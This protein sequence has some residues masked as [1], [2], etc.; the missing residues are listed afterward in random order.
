MPPDNH[1]RFQ[2]PPALTSV[3]V[4]YAA[5]I[6][7]VAS[8]LRLPKTLLN[9]I[10]FLELPV[11]LWGRKRMMQPVLITAMAL[12]GYQLTLNQLTLDAG[13]EKMMAQRS[14]TQ[15]VFYA[16]VLH[17][18]PQADR[19]RMDVM[20]DRISTQQV[21]PCSP[22][23]L[24]VQ[25]DSPGCPLLPG[26]RIAFAGKLRRPRLFGTPG[27]FNG[28]RHLAAQ[29]IFAT[30]FL[31]SERAIVRFAPTAPFSWPTQLSRWRTRLARQLA[32]AI[33]NANMPYLLS[34]TLGESSRLSTDQRDRLARGGLSHLFAI[35]GLHLGWI[36]SLC[37]LVISTLYRRSTRLLLWQPVQCATPFLILPLILFYVF[38]SG[39][40]LPTQRAAWMVVTGAIVA[41]TSYH[42]RPTSA[43]ILAAG[44]ILLANPLALLS[45][46][47]QLSFTAVAALM[48][49]LPAW[50]HLPRSWWRP[51]VLLMLG[52]TTALLATLP[53]SLWHFHTVAPAALI[54]NLLAIPLIGLVILPAA[55]LATLL[56]ALWPGP[57]SGLLKPLA[58]LLG[59]TLDLCESA[60]PS[61]LQGRLLYLTPYQHLLTGLA[62]LVLLLLL[63]RQI[64]C[65]WILGI[66]LGGLM[67]LSQIPQGTCDLGLSL[68]ALSVGQGEALLV[69]TPKGQQILVDG[70]GFPHSDFDVG[71]RLLAPAL[72]QLGVT[73]LDA[74]LLTHDHPDHREGLKHLLHHV[75]VDHFLTA[76][77]PDSM[78]AEL[79]TIVRKKQIP[80]HQL[81]EGW[82]MWD[83]TLHLFVPR[84]QRASM[85]DR[86]VALYAGLGDDGL[87]L[88]GD[89]EEA[90]M[91]QLLDAPPPG[92]VTLL[93]LPHHGSRHTLPERWLKQWSL[94]LAVVSCGFQNHFG[95]PHIEVRQRLEQ[96]EIPL[97]RTDLDGTVQAVSHGEGWRVRHLATAQNL[98]KSV[99]PSY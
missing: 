33:E 24:R 95:F 61:L 7:I 59:W 47:F 66:V 67:L 94:Q 18:T 41:L 85:N 64:R 56:F 44:L 17:I 46:S 71:R 12:L 13:L 87:L 3:L 72:A 79:A 84:Q 88:T 28:P 23:H 2:R 99:Q 9:A 22:F 49:V 69:T 8:G 63:A 11:L 35:S 62:C 60:T 55:L 80:L 20:V 25:I 76:L 31:N 32:S 6:L 42:A 40:A 19:W 65:G 70:G 97:L 57:A 73:R 75:P 82:Q 4:A 78:D 91:R 53:V 36:A 68:T 10:L 74:V 15:G 98:D 52:S 48:L 16:E 5:G 83:R 77:A 38:L 37:Y 51:L 30:T 34:L 54:T 29:G 27:E 14:G 1:Q 90:G 39:A 21:V 45:A 93:K 86:S 26:D 92:P 89:L 43:L 81:K 58:E 96:A 50:Q